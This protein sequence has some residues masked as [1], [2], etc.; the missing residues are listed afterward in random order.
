MFHS[1]ALDEDEAPPKQY[2]VTYGLT[3][4]DSKDEQERIETSIIWHVGAQVT[5]RVA[6]LKMFGK[7]NESNDCVIACVTQ[8]LLTF[9]FSPFYKGSRLQ[10]VFSGMTI[11]LLYF[12][13]SVSYHSPS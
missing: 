11:V 4:K 9:I 10:V 7:P 12:C 8:L 2:D 6:L 1:P 3:A 13:V 5:E